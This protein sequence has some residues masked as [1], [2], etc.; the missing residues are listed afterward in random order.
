MKNSFFLFFLFFLHC[1][2]ERSLSLWHVSGKK[3]IKAKIRNKHADVNLNDGTI[4]SKRIHNW[5]YV[6]IFEPPHDKTNKMRV[7]PA[8]TQISLGILPVWSES[9]LCAQWV[10][11]D[12]SFLH[13]DIEDS[14]Q[15]GRYLGLRASLILI[16]LWCGT[17]FILV[18]GRSYRGQTC[19]PRLGPVPRD[20]QN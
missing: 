10:G 7:R 14:D 9:S 8:K 1:L 3:I 5:K 2:R 19:G 18:L 11:K 15:T 6:L 17:W 4:K 13:A 12:P 20:I 16:P